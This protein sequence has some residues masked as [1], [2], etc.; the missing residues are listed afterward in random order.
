[1]RKRVQRWIVGYLLNIE[2]KHWKRYTTTLWEDWKKIE[3]LVVTKLIIGLQILHDE[4]NNNWKRWKGENSVVNVYV[5]LK[6]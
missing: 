1:M 3:D 4:L 5:K 6:Q 2:T